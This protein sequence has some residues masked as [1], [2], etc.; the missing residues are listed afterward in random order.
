MGDVI[1]IMQ[2]DHDESGRMESNVVWVSV[3]S[4]FDRNESVLCYLHSARSAMV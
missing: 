3:G 4:R 2:K 1:R